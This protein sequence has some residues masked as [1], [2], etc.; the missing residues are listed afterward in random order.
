MFK[1]FA[2]SSRCVDKPLLGMLELARINGKM[3]NLTVSVEQLLVVAGILDL[4]WLVFSPR[5]PF[6]ALILIDDRN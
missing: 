1:L 4:L 2:V 5:F 3:S 6:R